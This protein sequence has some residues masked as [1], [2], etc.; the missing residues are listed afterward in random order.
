MGY[1]GASEVSIRQSV[2]SSPRSVPVCMPLG[3]YLVYV[4]G[5]APAHLGVSCL[6]DG[7]P[8]CVRVRA[9]YLLLLLLPPK[10]SDH[11]CI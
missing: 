11:L 5:H 1:L 4:T 2:W 6:V 9:I 8:G 3:M 10:T 7:G